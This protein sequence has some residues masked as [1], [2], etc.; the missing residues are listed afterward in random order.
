MRQ[1]WLNANLTIGNSGF[2]FC[3]FLMLPQ[4]DFAASGGPMHGRSKAMK[5]IPCNALFN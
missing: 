2:V 5:D 1:A 3:L 4:Q